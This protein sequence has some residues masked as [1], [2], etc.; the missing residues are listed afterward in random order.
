MSKVDIQK[1]TIQKLF[2]LSL[3]EGKNVGELT[4]ELFEDY[5]N[6]KMYKYTGQHGNKYEIKRS[7]NIVI[8]DLTISDFVD[9]I[10]FDKESNNSTL[11]DGRAVIQ[12]YYGDVAKYIKS[13]DRFSINRIKL[14]F[15]E[16]GDIMK[17]KDVFKD[18]YEEIKLF[19]NIGIN[20]YK[21]ISV[22]VVPEKF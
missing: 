19:N 10:I 8:P 12:E 18:I 11:V 16:Y 3:T 6:D 4:I 14:A 21:E 1:D 7:I 9:N 20:Y 2:D 22:F 13:I 15:K 17:E 5:V